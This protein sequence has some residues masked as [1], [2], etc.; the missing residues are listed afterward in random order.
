VVVRGDRIV[1]VG[2]KN[3]VQPPEGAMVIDGRRRFL[4]PGFAEMH[5]HIPPPAAPPQFIEDVLFMYVANGVTTVRGMLGA[6]GQLELR[7]KARRGEII[8]PTLYLAGPSFNAGSIKSAED[9]IQRVRQQKKEGWDLLKIHPGPTREQY[10]AMAAT[11]REVGIRWA[12]HVPAEVGILHAL[13]AGQETIDHLDG[14]I[15]HLGGDKGPLETAKL[16]EMAKLTKQAG[17]GVVPTMALWDTLTGAVS[18]E[19][20][21]S[22]PELRYM[23][24]AMVTNWTNLHQQRLASPQFNKEAARHISANRKRLLRAMDL[25]GVRVLFGTDAPQQFS[26]PGFSILREMRVM[27]EAGM[28]SDRILYSGTVA[29]GVYF[30]S[31]DTFGKIAAGAR[32]DLVLLEANPLADLGGFANRAGVVLRG[33]WIPQKEIEERLERIAAAAR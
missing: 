28:S 5:G 30:K 24:Q 26:V 7:E 4:M 19:H 2:P 33:R 23:P 32:A 3:K 16:V 6:P 20:L 25:Q 18:L 10:D 14:Y 27:A 31:Q 8:A 13:Q 29:P 21:T 22:Y 11:A 12:G 9:A 1:A 17:A 15:E